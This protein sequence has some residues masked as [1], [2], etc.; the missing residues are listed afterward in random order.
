MPKSI[1]YLIFFSF[2]LQVQGNFTQASETTTKV[3]EALF[4]PVS[5][6]CTQCKA[7]A[8]KIKASAYMLG[9]ATVILTVTVVFSP[10]AVV[11]TA[12]GA[13]LWGY[14]EVTYH[15]CALSDC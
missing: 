1:F 13:V 14:G 7:E 12:L 2:L 5:M 9:I 15:I 10:L 8:D 6:S 3:L 4:I 11:T